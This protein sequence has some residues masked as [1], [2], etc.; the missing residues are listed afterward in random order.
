MIPNEVLESI[1]IEH[2]R[3]IV[4]RVE[5][6]IIGELEEHTDYQQMEW[7]AINLALSK[8]RSEILGC[9]TCRGYGFLKRV[10]NDDKIPCGACNNPWTPSST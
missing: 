8:I 2:R 9:S 5:N 10:Q 3:A 7:Y 6:H 4:A 1:P